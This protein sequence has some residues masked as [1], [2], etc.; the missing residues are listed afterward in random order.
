[1]I[2][3][4]D[5]CVLLLLLCV[6]VTF[7]RSNQHS[8]ERQGVW[9]LSKLPGPDSPLHNPLVSLVKGDEKVS[10]TASCLGPFCQI[11]RAHSHAYSAQIVHCL[12]WFLPSAVHCTR[13]PCHLS[14]PQL[15]GQARCGEEGACG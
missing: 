12:T 8:N 1:M 9:D 15:A 11:G 4:D 5:I 10:G 13:L 14:G 6:Q 7:M 3:E 2:K